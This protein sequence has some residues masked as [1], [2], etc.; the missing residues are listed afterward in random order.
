MNYEEFFSASDVETF[1][2][3]KLGQMHLARLAREIAAEMVGG[4]VEGSGKEFVRTEQG[5]FRLC[6]RANS[7]NTTERYAHHEMGAKTVVM[8]NDEDMIVFFV[9]HGVL[10]GLPKFKKAVRRRFR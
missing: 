2:R 3:V 7:D 9:A 1:K 4:T 8:S 10:L 6:A 5:V